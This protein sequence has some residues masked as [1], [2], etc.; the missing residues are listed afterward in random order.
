MLGR[1]VFRTS[2]LCKGLNSNPIVPKR[3]NSNA[4]VPSKANFVSTDSKFSW[5]AGAAIGTAL[6]AIPLIG[7]DEEDKGPHTPGEKEKI[8][9]RIGEKLAKVVQKHSPINEFDTHL[10]AVLVDSRNPDKQ[11]PVHLYVSHINEDFMQALI[12][13]DETDDARLIG[14]EY[15]ITP[16][17]FDQLTVEERKLWHSLNY[18]VRSGVLVAP[19]LPAVIEHKLMKDLAPTYG[20]A[21]YIWNKEDSF[22]PVGIPQF[23]SAPTHEGVLKLSQIEKLF[24][25]YG[26]DWEKIRNSREDIRENFPLIGIDLETP[27]IVLEAKT[28]PPK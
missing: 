12:M 5:R 9:T 14:I 6:A 11:V 23:L 7:R 20:K 18:L 17:L 4:K 26:Y 15:I 16:K 28:I 1:T 10:T 2:S 27:R 22:L 19:R 8:S 3:F 21:I 24:H 13:D 25:K